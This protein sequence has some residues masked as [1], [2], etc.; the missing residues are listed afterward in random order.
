VQCRTGYANRHGSRASV[1]YLLIV[2]L[3]AAPS[4]SIG[5]NGPDSIAQI[6][7]LTRQWIDLEHQSDELQA[8]WRKDKPV[9]EQQLALLERESAQLSDYL[10]ASAQQ[11]DEVDQRRLELLEEQ[12]RLEREQS[13]LESR[14]VQTAAALHSL[15]SQLPPPV[16]E[17]WT[18]QL[19]RLDDPLLT[20]TEKLQ[21][22]VELLGQLDDFQQKV[23]LHETVMTL[24]DGR[25]YEV[26][27]VYLGLSHGWYVTT[28]ERFA[29]AGT[30]TPDGW[31]WSAVPDAE[32]ITQIIDIIERRQVP[33]LVSIPLTLQAPPP[34]RGD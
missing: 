18:E 23:T 28:D 2:L 29:A 1:R 14:L 12:T 13:V 22:C 21:V 5:Q 30:A 3:G 4:A 25:D 7:A 26:R 34:G 11:R 24:P 33:E 20:A 19:P 8:N 17:A 27:Q 9:L 32:P 31:Q 15:Q 16:V 6:D 10:E